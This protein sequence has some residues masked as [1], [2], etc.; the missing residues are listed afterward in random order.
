[1]NATDELDIRLARGLRDALHP[2]S[3]ALEMAL[4]SGADI[5]AYLASPA[6]RLERARRIHS[7]AVARFGE[8]LVTAAAKRG[9]GCRWCLA[10]SSA[11]VLGGPGPQL[12]SKAHR[13][14]LGGEPC[15]RCWR[16]RKAVLMAR[17]EA[18]LASCREM[19]VASAASRKYVADARRYHARKAVAHTN[20][21]AAAR[22]GISASAVRKAFPEET[23][24]EF[25]A[26]VVR[27]RALQGRR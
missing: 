14:L 2:S 7:T 16:E 13:V 27:R 15:P 17:A 19:L 20:R 10:R 5:G 9:T 1:M 24:E 18:T 25:L 12:D 11:R 21:A 8:P 4:V 3:S 22:L 23:G 26:S 6:E